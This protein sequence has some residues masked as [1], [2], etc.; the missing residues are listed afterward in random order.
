MCSSVD[1]H[2]PPFQC[3][4]LGRFSALRDGF[5]LPHD[6]IGRGDSSCN[7]PLLAH[8]FE[9]RLGTLLHQLLDSADHISHIKH[10][11]AQYHNHVRSLRFQPPVV[12]PRRRH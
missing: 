5:H 11:V 4:T 6:E 7:R 1:T 9:C 10:T 12:A 2:H 8:D 3:S